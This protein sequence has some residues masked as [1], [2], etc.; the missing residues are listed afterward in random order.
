MKLA[1]SVK[2]PTLTCRPLTGARIETP[3][4]NQGRRA[5]AVAPSRGRGLKQ[6]S[7]FTDTLKLSSPPHGG[8]D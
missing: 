5:T 3:I 2:A 8:A 1:A 4:H 7:G 6:E